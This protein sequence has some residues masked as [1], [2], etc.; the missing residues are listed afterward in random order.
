[1]LSHDDGKPFRALLENIDLYKVGH[2]G[3]RN[4][5]PKSLFEL[6][7]NDTEPRRPMVAM[8]STKPDVHVR[9]GPQPVPKPTLVDAITSRMTL[10]RTDHLLPDQ[11][12][13]EVSATT[14]PADVFESVPE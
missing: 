11:R 3:S 14:D 8:L 10:V 12:Y 4:A 2:H 9:D 7:N 13:L 1:M 6:W 5:T